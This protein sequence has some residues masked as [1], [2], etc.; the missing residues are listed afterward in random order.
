MRRR[1]GILSLCWPTIWPLFTSV[2]LVF[3]IVVWPS[4]WLILEAEFIYDSLTGFDRSYIY[5]LGHWPRVDCRSTMAL[6]PIFAMDI[7][8]WI[9]ALWP[10]ASGQNSSHCCRCWLGPALTISLSFYFFDLAFIEV[11]DWNFNWNI[12][13]YILMNW[14]LSHKEIFLCFPI[15]GFFPGH[16]PK[17]CCLLSHSFY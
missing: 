15:F 13:M 8:G 7:V 4:S 16:W 5:V 17:I 12:M 14:T 9:L 1:R 3:F 10:A 6:W 11:I 2:D